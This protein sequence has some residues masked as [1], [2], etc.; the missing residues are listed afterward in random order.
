MEKFEAAEE[1][2]EPGLNKV[3]RDGPT[4]N[5]ENIQDA[6]HVGQKGSPQL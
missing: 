2:N 3:Q 1:I 6:L 5:R 4:L